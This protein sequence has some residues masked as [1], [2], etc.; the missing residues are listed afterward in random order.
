MTQRIGIIG[1]G[2]MG[3]GIAQVFAM[4]GNTV[5]LAD[6][7]EKAIERA[8][9]YLKSTFHKL[10]EKQKITKQQAEDFFK[11]INFTTVLN[12]ETFSDQEII[13][14]AIVE[15]LDVK[16]MIFLQLENLLPKSCIFASNTSS[17]SITS[18]ASACQ[19][20]DRVIGIHFFNPAPL[21]PLVEIIP[22][23]ATAKSVIVKSSEI[24]S[25]LNKT[26]VLCK[27]TPEIGR[28]HV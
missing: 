10:E 13:I 5:T 27:D 1:S 19:F 2:A 4:A 21:M 16:Q 20:P 9:N 18:I 3:T 24:I 25:S 7:N 26:V 22:G 14:E 6:E 11:A 23:I 28:A 15:R 17:L 8:K 12:S